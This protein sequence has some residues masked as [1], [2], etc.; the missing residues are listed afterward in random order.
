MYHLNALK[1]LSLVRLESSMY[2][3][4][5]E[6]AACRL[7]GTEKGSRGFGSKNTSAG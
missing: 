7:E 3:V 1:L 4:A 2:P 6:V 5:A